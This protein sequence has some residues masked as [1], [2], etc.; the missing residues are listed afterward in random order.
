MNTLST[1]SHPIVNKL[2]EALFVFENSKLD[3]LVLNNHII[4]RSET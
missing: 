1:F 2:Q 3:G 4:K